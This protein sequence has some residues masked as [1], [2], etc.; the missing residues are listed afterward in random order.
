MVKVPG[1]WSSGPVERVGSVTFRRRQLP[2]SNGRVRVKIEVVVDG[3]GTV[4]EILSGRLGWAYR[5]TRTER[6]GRRTSQSILASR[7]WATAEEA[8]KA[9]A[10]AATAEAAQSARAAQSAIS[11]LTQHQP[12]TRGRIARGRMCD[13]NVQGEGE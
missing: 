1:K 6:T 5:A 13:G 11:D 4:G 12:G 2:L 3:V 8:K 10:A 7:V 9:I